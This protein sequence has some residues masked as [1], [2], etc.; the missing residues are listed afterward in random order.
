[1]NK[2][3]RAAIVEAKSAK[4]PSVVAATTYAGGSGYSKDEEAI[5]IVVKVVALSSS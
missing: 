1:M 2:T 3:A 4:A 5:G